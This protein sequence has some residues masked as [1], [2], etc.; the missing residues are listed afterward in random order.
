MR[1]WLFYPLSPLSPLSPSGG[2]GRP[3][4]KLPAK[5][6]P[7]LNPAHLRGWWTRDF[8]AAL[9]AFPDSLW[10]VPGSGH[11]CDFS[12][13]GGSKLHWMAPARAVAARRGRGEGGAGGEG[14]GE[15][16]G[17]E[18]S[19]E[20]G[21]WVLEG[22]PSLGIPECALHGPIALASL[23][24]HGSTAAQPTDVVEVAEAA[25]VAKALEAAAGSLEGGVN[26][27]VLLLQFERECGAAGEGEAGCW[28][29]A[30]R[31]F[32]MPLAWDP[33]PLC[34]A[35]PLGL[36]RPKRAKVSEYR[37]A[38]AAAAAGASCMRDGDGGRP[39]SVSP[40]QEE[41]LLANGKRGGASRDGASRGGGSGGGGGDGDGDGGSGGGGGGGGGSG[42]GGGGGGGCEEG[43]DGATAAGAPTRSGVF[44]KAVYRQNAP[45]SAEQTKQLS[46]RLG[47]E[48]GY[49]ALTKAGGTSGC[50]GW[51]GTLGGVGSAVSGGAPGAL[52]P[53]GGGD[54]VDEVERAVAALCISFPRLAPPLREPLARLCASF[55]A[56]VDA[57]G[58]LSVQSAPSTEGHF[59]GGS[60]GGNGDGGAGEGND[61]GAHA[62]AA[63]AAAA[64]AGGTQAEVEFLASVRCLFAR[65]PR[66]PAQKVSAGAR[67]YAAEVG[68]TSSLF[69]VAREVPW[70]RQLVAFSLPISPPLTPKV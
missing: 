54:E 51:D 59:G 68:G 37:T 10:A 62:A 13:G 23:L 52:P 56:A 33:A 27:S 49:T 24:R 7:D 50:G 57:C 14:G 65:P 66:P 31:G 48:G 9:R 34:V 44:N 2:P 29:E 19:N 11:V 1:G 28:V 16:R 18:R 30:S 38:A 42:G 60:E 36:S 40:S 64:A 6:A 43:F 17:G 55:C 47:K 20:G 15:G 63:A 22:L 4:I 5:L 25:E 12:G 8:S 41:V 21:G 45:P 46:I 26:T 53:D 70:P 67:R 32:L 58:A 35:S 61:E 69:A 3:S 39:C